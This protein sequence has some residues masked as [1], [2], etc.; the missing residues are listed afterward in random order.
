MFLVL[1]PIAN[2]D[3]VR[4]SFLNAPT[5]ISCYLEDYTVTQSSYNVEMI[6]INDHL[7]CTT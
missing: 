3:G 6:S 1:T 5:V 2:T 7:I 4:I